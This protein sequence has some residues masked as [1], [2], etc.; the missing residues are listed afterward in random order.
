MTNIDENAKRDAN[1]VKDLSAFAKKFLIE[2]NGGDLSQ[3]EVEE[4]MFNGDKWVVTVSY[5]RTI[6][7]PNELQRTLGIFGRRAYKRITIDRASMQVLGMSE[8]S[9]EMREAA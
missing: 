1:K 7:S 6:N 4:V 2:L 3:F 5:V 9:P 8:W